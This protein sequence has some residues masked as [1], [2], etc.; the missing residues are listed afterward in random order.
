MNLSPHFTF[1]ELVTTQHREFVQQNRDW[2]MAKLPMLRRLAVEFL[3]PV[4]ELLGVALIVSSGV[5]CPPLNRAVGGTGPSAHIDGRAADFIAPAFGV[6]YDV[7]RAI[8][9]SNIPFDQ[10]IYEHTW[11]HGS[12]AL[13]PA[14]NRR[15][16]LTLM[17]GGGYQPGIVLR[18]AV[19]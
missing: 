15:Q 7:A 14:Q 11:V 1:D 18:A 6:P 19:A 2:G 10:L 9:D 13:Q 12:I 17:A 4:R 5:R 3:E 16:V 8:R